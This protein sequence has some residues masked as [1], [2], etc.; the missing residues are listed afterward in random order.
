LDI[1]YNT[2]ATT[3][4]VKAFVTQYNALATQIGKLRSYD[5]ATKVAGPLLG[6]AM[7]NTIEGQVRVAISNPVSGLTGDYTSLASVGIKSNADGTLALDT[8]K[9]QKAFDKDFSAVGKIF[10]STDGVAARLYGKL[11]LFLASNGQI[12]ARNVSLDKTSKDA[13]KQIQALNARMVVVEERFR[14]QFT[15]LDTVLS[16]LQS[17]SSYLS[18]Q[19]ASTANIR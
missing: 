1:A 6:D 12:A 7:L 19:L 10:G 16:Q 15:A 11:D 3:D 17:T 18:Q 14:K 4:K 9:L 8:A 2:T 5:A 13:D